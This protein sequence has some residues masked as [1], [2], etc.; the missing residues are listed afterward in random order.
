MQPNQD[1]ITK[2]QLISRFTAFNYQMKQL[3]PDTFDAKEFGWFIT[4]LREMNLNDFENQKADLLDKV[5][6]MYIFEQDKLS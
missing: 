2:N 6:Y 1:N 4:R 3:Y 5:K